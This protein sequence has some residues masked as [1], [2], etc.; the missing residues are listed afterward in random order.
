MVGLVSIAVSATARSGA[1]ITSQPQPC[2]KVSMP[3]S[4]E[5]SLS[6]QSAVV[7]T[8]WLGSTRMSSR[9]GKS[10]ATQPAADQHAPAR[11]VFDG[12]G[13]EVLHQPAQ[14]PAVGAH[15]Q[16]TAHEGE[17]EPF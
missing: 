14:Q 10:T 17:V 12:V 11:R 9:A 13:D 4:T 2:N 5:G 1:L 6:M 8:S 3:S 7:P 16:R 15:H